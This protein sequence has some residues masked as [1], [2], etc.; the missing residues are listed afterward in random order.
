M[1]PPH[2]LPR[3]DDLP[4]RPCPRNASPSPPSPSPPLLPQTLCIRFTSVVPFFVF[5]GHPCEWAVVH[6][7]H[8]PCRRCNSRSCLAARQIDIHSARA[9]GPIAPLAA[10]AESPATLAARATLRAWLDTPALPLRLKLCFNRFPGVFRCQIGYGI[11]N[12][13]FR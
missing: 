3:P 5:A 13:T 10:W 2:L 6:V 8:C 4:P 12:H 7:V 11:L 1:V 9:Y